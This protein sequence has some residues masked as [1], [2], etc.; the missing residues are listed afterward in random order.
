MSFS[1][2]GGVTHLLGERFERSGVVRT[3]GDRKIEQNKV[4]SAIAP[5]DNP[6]TSGSSRYLEESLMV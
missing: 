2:N 3:D 5:E 4:K 6:H 1:L